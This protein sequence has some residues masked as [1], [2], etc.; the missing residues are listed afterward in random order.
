MTQDL[1][2]RSPSFGD[3]NYDDG[4]SDA[5]SSEQKMRTSYLRWT[6]QLH[7]T[8]RDGMAP[9]SPMLVHGIGESVRR[10]QTI[11]GV[12]RPEDITTEPLPDPDE[13][14]RTTPQSEWER[15]LDGSVGAGWKHEVLRLSREPGDR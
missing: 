14:N 5:P 13:L 2:K 4:F 7:W 3:N 9:P 12:K 1:A 6:E 8:D 15:Q 11:D 10:W